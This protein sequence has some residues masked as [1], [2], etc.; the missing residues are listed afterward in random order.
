[1]K[2]LDAKIEWLFKRKKN[3]KTNEKMIGR[4]SHRRR[5]FKDVFAAST[6]P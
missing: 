1:M 3:K 2:I 6:K 4:G 5:V